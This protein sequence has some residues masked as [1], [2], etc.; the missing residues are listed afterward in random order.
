MSLFCK[1]SIGGWALR[2]LRRCERSGGPA[3]HTAPAQGL[4]PEKG[5]PD[6]GSCKDSAAASPAQPASAPVSP[7]GTRV[8]CCRA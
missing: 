7:P 6:Q 2:G 4:I 8:I 1:R 3:S 5:R